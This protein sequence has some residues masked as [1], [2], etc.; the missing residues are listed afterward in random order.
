MCDRLN[1]VCLGQG[2]WLSTAAQEVGKL[3]LANL[4]HE[5][6]IPANAR[7][8]RQAPGRSDHLGKIV[9]SSVVEVLGRLQDT[10]ADPQV[11]RLLAD[12][13][14]FVLRRGLDSVPSLRSS[15]A[16]STTTTGSSEETPGK[17]SARPT[18]SIGS[19]TWAVST[20]VGSPPPWTSTTGNG[21][22][23]DWSRATRF[24][25]PLDGAYAVC[26]KCRRPLDRAATLPALG[27]DSPV[28]REDSSSLSGESEHEFAGCIEC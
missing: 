5:N 28:L 13:R 22:S 4:C 26:S 11:P 24:V 2:S 16:T 7:V 6:Q 19:S 20:A 23:F 17:A 15:E 9:V 1:E 18:T 25:E 3:S 27:T 14:A 12:V 10:A 8:L 21:P